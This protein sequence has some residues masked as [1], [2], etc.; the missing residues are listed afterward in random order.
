MQTPEEEK[1]LM[2]KAEL[3][4][5]LVTFLAGRASE[6]IFFESV[7][8]GASNDIEKATK[9]ARAM[10]TRYG[11][12][13]EFGL[14]GLETIEG[15][16]LDGRAVLN[17]GEQTAAKVDAVV[18]GMLK[19]AYQKA[20]ELISSNKMAMNRIAGFLI[21]KETI[22]GKEFMKILQEVED[23]KKELEAQARLKVQE[24]DAQQN[25]PEA[26]EEE[27]KD[28]GLDDVWADPAPSDAAEPEKAEKEK[29]DRT[30]SEQE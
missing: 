23:E 15:Q 4:A 26:L 2:T 28:A 6:E 21:E 17:C 5:E 20:K 16:Y 19:D 25:I 7:S 18:M 14:M 3:E 24:A 9:I 27:K 22:T 30:D 10:V 11:M 1:F 12:S 29:T 13:D 8:T